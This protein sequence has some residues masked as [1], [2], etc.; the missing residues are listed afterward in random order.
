MMGR[1]PEPELMDDEVQAR[2]YAEADFDAPHTLFVELLAERVGELSGNALDLGCGPG[3]IVRRV[4]ERFPFVSID[5]VEGAAAMAALARQMVEARGL[6]ARVRIHH[7]YLPTDR[8]VEQGYDAVLSNSLL[9]HLNEPMVL[10]ETVARCARPGAQVFIMD[11]LRPSSRAA[12]QA[13]VDEY[14]DGEP[15]VLRRDFFNS[16][17]AAYRLEEVADQLARAGLADLRLE[18][19]SDRHWIA[20]GVHLGV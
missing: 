14:A 12:A 5:G 13:L 2:A 20:Y 6:S 1:I 4:V 7:L 9:H 17:L 18:Q 8:L 3:D 16:L 19:V 11:L 10:W 15:E